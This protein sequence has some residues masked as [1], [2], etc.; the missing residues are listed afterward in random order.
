MFEVLRELFSSLVGWLDN[1]VVKLL[2]YVVSP[3]MALVS[4]VYARLDRKELKAS[5]AEL[6]TQAEALGRA[7][8]E[9]AAAN[10]VF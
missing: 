9:A 2:S 10:Q 6:A 8:A 1:P 4:F 3:I 5:T 7:K